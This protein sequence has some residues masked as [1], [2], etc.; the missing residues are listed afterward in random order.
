MEPDSRETVYEGGLI[1]V[2][3]ERWDG[4]VR[5]IVEPPDAVAVVAVDREGYVTLVRQ[6]REAARAELL[7]LPAGGIEAGETPLECAKRELAEETGLTGGTWRHAA[8]FYTTP[9]FCR[10]RM[11][12]FIAEELDR[13]EASP[14]ADEQFEH[15]RV[16][17][18][19]LDAL[20]PEI[21]DAKTLSGLLLFLRDDA[22][23]KGL[24]SRPLR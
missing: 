2:V 1:D 6:L 17:V 22:F 5:E 21:E 16:S 11:D 12:V 13:G 19:E 9:G 20:L 14:V 18:G 15:V 24:E 3:V 8:S 7:E 4:R 10:E 23:T